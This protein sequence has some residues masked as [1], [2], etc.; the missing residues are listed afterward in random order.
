MSTVTLKDSHQRTIGYIETRSDGIQVAKDAHKR[1]KG[2]YDPKT[3]KT[4]DSHS[5]TDGSGNL[6]T[7]L[8]TCP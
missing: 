8:I 1:T 4:T 6:L 5:I 7:T 2:Y 3:N